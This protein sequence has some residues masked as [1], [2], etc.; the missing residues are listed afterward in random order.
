MPAWIYTL[1]TT[2]MIEAR[3]QIPFLDLIVRL[4]FTVLPCLAG[5]LISIFIPKLK[6]YVVKIAKPFANF[7]VFTFLALTIYTKLYSFGL[8]ETKQWLY[9]PFIPFFGFSIGGLV[10]FLLKF[11]LKQVYTIAIETGRQ[12]FCIF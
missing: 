3:I 8:V 7:I 12:G 1:G 11:P 6:T 2:L 4:L 5:V 10:A 9:A